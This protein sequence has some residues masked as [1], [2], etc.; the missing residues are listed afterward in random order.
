MVTLTVNKRGKGKKSVFS[1]AILDESIE[2]FNLINERLGTSKRQTL[3]DMI[4]VMYS[5][6]QEVESGGEV[7]LHHPSSDKPTKL[8]IL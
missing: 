6:I 1:H 3:E 2:K 8:N 4:D 5:I 7:M